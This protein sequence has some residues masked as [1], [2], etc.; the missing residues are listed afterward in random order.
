MRFGIYAEMQ[1]PDDKPFAA[2]YDEVFRQ[3][4]HADEV[5][6]DSYSIIEHHLFR[7]FGISANPL[8]MITAVAQ[9]TEKIRFR[10]LL[11]TLPFH[12]PLRLAAEIAVADILTGGRLDCGVGRG[13][14][15]LYGPLNV[16][17]EESRPRFDEALEVLIKA[18]TQDRFSH[19]GE[20][21]EFEDV[22]VVPKP[23]QKPHP[24][25]YTGGTSDITYQMAG[26]RDWGICVPPV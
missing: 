7:N 1:C 17:L 13:H 9:K 26:E 19:K 23:L 11:H 16:P 12:N 3:M 5:G 8:A 24:K 15:W 20:F 6:F 14:A 25:L 18:W 22:A 10:T 4:V 21:W 2:L